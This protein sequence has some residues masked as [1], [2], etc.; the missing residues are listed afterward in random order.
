MSQHAPRYGTVIERRA[1]HLLIK[2]DD[3][4]WYTPTFGIQIASGVRGEPDE[5]VKLVWITGPSYG[6][7]Q[8]QSAAEGQ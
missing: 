7:W 2:G 4:Q 3:G 5:R 1:T 6:L 8:T